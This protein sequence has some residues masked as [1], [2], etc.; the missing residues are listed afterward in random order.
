M[1]GLEI[2]AKDE[3]CSVLNLLDSSP[4]LSRAYMHII[5]FI[6]KETMHKDVGGSGL[7]SESDMV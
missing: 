3:I 5:S 4:T 2:S 1:P 7:S 6:T